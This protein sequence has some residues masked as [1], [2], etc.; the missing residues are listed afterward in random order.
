MKPIIVTTDFS[1]AAANALDYAAALAQAYQFRI[2][3]THVYTI[4]VAYAGEGLSLAAVNDDMED[5]RQ[6]LKEELGRVKTQYP[7][8][9]IEGDIAVGGFLE[10]LQRLTTALDPELMVMGASRDYSELWQWGDD[11]LEALV[12]IPCPVLIVPPGIH[13]KPVKKIAFACDY[14]KICAPHQ[15]NTIKRMVQRAGATLHIIHV[16]P[17]AAKMAENK[18]VTELQQAFA[19]LQP[20]YHFIEDKHIIKGVSDFTEQ[21]QIDLLLVMPHKHDLWYSLFNKS[22]TK[23]LARLNH[24][25][26]MAIHETE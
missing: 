2:V 9:S 19:D 7:D 12:S 17:Q 10:S 22:Y 25:P 6:R 8:L 13:Y 14:K 15:V 26:V 18:Q 5:S 23:Q 3:L 4:P 16:T 11:W 21:H 20:Q 24:L 1:P